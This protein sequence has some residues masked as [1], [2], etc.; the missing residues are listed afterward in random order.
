M[1]LNFAHNGGTRFPWYHWSA[2]D[3]DA[4]ILLPSKKERVRTRVGY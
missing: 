1:M 2:S 3:Q 4:S